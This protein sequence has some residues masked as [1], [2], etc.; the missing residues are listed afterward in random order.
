[1]QT[2]TSSGKSHE[3]SMWTGGSTVTT[4][5]WACTVYQQSLSLNHTTQKWFC[6]QDGGGRLEVPWRWWWGFMSSVLLCWVARLLIPDILKERTD[7]IYKGPGVKASLNTP[8]PLYMKVVQWVGGSLIPNI[9]R[10][11]PPSKYWKSIT[12]L[13]NLTTQNG[14]ILKTGVTTN[15]LRAE[16]FQY[17]KWKICTHIWDQNEDI[18]T[19]LPKT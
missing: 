9:W 12:L 17:K 1:M 5:T 16:M 19:S 7:L 18:L 13:L 6:K 15:T 11:A 4:N 10:N 14:W 8:W 3:V 2:I